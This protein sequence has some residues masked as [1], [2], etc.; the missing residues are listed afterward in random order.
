MHQYLTQTQISIIQKALKLGT[1]TFSLIPLVVEME[2][3][4]DSGLTIQIPFSRSPNIAQAK[5]GD[6]KQNY[7]VAMQ[8]GKA[9]SG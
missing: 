9:T 4:D 3:K 7:T 6:L 1:I 2:A 5:P 8:V